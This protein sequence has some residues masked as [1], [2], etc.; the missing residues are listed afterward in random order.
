MRYARMCLS[1][2]GR[3]GWIALGFGIVL[4]GSALEAQWVRCPAEPASTCVP[5]RI[6]N[7]VVCS[8]PGGYVEFPSVSHF[9]VGCHDGTIATNRELCVDQPNRRECHPVEVYYPSDPAR[10]R[11]VAVAANGGVRLT[12]GKITCESCHSGASPANHY[13]AVDPLT[14][15]LCQR[16][17]NK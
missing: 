14:G 9:C 10:F 7:R 13:L 4:G 5:G 3:V 15:Q 1:L 8:Q 12:F 2:A 6:D 11:Q 16:C 17:H